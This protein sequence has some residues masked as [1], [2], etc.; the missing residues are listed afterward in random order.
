[1]LKNCSGGIENMNDKQKS[2]GVLG[3]AIVLALT[4]YW[5]ISQ[6]EF[7]C[8]CKPVLPVILVKLKNLEERGDSRQMLLRFDDKTGSDPLNE[9]DFSR[10]SRISSCDIRGNQCI[11]SRARFERLYVDERKQS[12]QIRL[13]DNQGNRLIGGVIWEKPAYPDRIFLSCDLAEPDQKMAASFCEQIP[14]ILPMPIQ[15]LLKVRTIS[16]CRDRQKN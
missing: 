10:Q 7:E 11:G 14:N 1:M 12:I 2:F 15:K 16:A 3:A 13:L 9:E 4:S 8:T 6:L 5:Y